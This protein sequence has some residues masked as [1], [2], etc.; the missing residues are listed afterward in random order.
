MTITCC[1]GPSHSR[2]A[3]FHYFILRPLPSSD[4]PTTT[5]PPSPLPINNKM[6]SA[7]QHHLHQHPAYRKASQAFLLRKYDAAFATCLS[8]L[9]ALPAETHQSA[10]TAQLRARLWTLYVNIA[11]ALASA[12]SASAAKTTHIV[13]VDGQTVDLGG[14]AEKVVD[15]VWRQVVH[16]YD[17]VEGD[18][19]GNVVVACI[20]MSLTRHA[21]KIGRQITESWLSSI[22]DSVLA[23]LEQSATTT[24]TTTTTEDDEP[25]RRRGHDPVLAAYDRIIEL[26]LLHV[27]PALHDF[28]S[29]KEFVNYNPYVGEEMKKKY[30][31]TLDKLQEKASRPPKKRS[32]SAIKKPTT[33]HPPPTY[34]QIPKHNGHHHPTTFLDALPSSDI[35]TQHRP[36]RTS[37][38]S[39]TSSVHPADLIANAYP[40]SPTTTSPPFSPPFSPPSSVSSS[41]RLRASTPGGFK[42][43][44]VPQHHTPTRRALDVAMRVPDFI[45]RYVRQLSAQGSPLVLLIV[46]VVVGVL[47][48]GRRG[49]IWDAFKTVLA[50]L[51]QTVRM[52]TKITYM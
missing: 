5:P 18:V 47:V 10:P 52:G 43:V 15:F 30:V 21:P 40:P 48:G 26:Y 11:S 2:S 46:M 23:H 8:A 35:H 24:T 9:A 13:G 44:N 33:T 51:W 32:S 28:E 25:Q 20:M 29:A 37:F 38:S 19:D 49:V 16:G 39:S 17:E 1:N 41:P 42:R 12:S 14:G 6:T 50:K 36:P 31:E 34:A 4:H 3:C 22:P 45:V 7:T 27:L